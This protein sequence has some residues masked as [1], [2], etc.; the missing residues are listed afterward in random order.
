MAV[1]I[2]ETPV[3]LQTDPIECGAVCLGIVLEYLGHYA[4]NFRL[5]SV[6]SVSRHG[7]QADEIIKGASSFGLVGEAKNILASDLQ[8]LSGPIVLFFDQC[9]FVVFEGYFLGRYYLNDPARGRYTLTAQV[10]HQR[11]SRVAIFLSPTPQFVSR[12]TKNMVPKQYDVA[13]IFLVFL[14]FISGFC[15]V[16][17]ALIA[18]FVVTKGYAQV[19]MPL[20]LMPIGVIGLLAV[21]LVSLI[22]MVQIIAAVAAEQSSED[23]SFLQKSLTLVPMS[24]FDDVPF[25]SLAKSYA[26][27]LHNSLSYCMWLLPRYFFSAFLLVIV[28]A[29]IGIA[30]L[31]SVV[32]TLVMVLYALQVFLVRTYIPQPHFSLARYELEQALWLAPDMMAMGHYDFVCDGL[33]QKRINLVPQSLVTARSVGIFSLIFIEAAMVLVVLAMI[34][35]ELWQ[36]GGISIAEI[37]SSLVLGWSMMVSLAFL[38][39]GRSNNY[40]HAFQAYKREIAE[41]LRGSYQAEIT[42]TD[43]IIELSNVSFAYRGEKIAVLQNL[44]LLIKP[45]Q[46]IGIAAPSR[47]GKSTLLR[48]LAG[49]IAPTAGVIIH[50]HALRS[51]LIDDDANVLPATL[52]DNIALFDASIDDQAVVDALSQACAVDLYYNRPFGLMAPIENKGINLSDS[53]KKRILLAQGLAHHPDVVLL[54]NF[55]S[56]IDE[57]KTQ[58]IIKNLASRGITTIFTLDR[59]SETE[60]CDQVITLTRTTSLTEGGL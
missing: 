51:A 11:F 24:F 58:K 59:Q 3:R 15:F 18:G 33:L 39:Y 54:D 31:T 8:S 44:S 1:F 21:M 37:M 17:L 30:P 29:L 10:F 60:L 9:H 20:W 57:E 32:I 16:V 43:S 13:K 36:Q 55:F 28:I 48:L 45:G 7:A 22:T 6:C 34:L 27:S 40:D 41:Q 42:D 2:N 14:G 50:S 12:K 4:T 35:P 49:R 47:S 26:G 56:G 46:I 38:S 25:S 23:T 53:E 52:R 5:R 19:S